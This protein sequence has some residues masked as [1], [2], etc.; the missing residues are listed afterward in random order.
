MRLGVRPLAIV[1][2]LGLFVFATETHLIAWNEVTSFCTQWDQNHDCSCSAS[3][4]GGWEASGNCDFSQE[5]DWET[6]ATAYCSD[7]FDACVNDCES[8]EYQEW[9]A[10]HECDQWNPGPECIPG[11]WVTWAGTNSCDVG[12]VPSF[13]CVCDGMMICEP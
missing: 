3:Q 9:L 1:V 2:M 7:A 11:C 6:F 8:S 4:V 10:D 5:Q 12:E 13:S